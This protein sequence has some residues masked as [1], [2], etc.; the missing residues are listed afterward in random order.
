MSYKAKL[1]IADAE[2]I[3]QYEKKILSQIAPQYV[4][5]YREHKIEE[6]KKQELMAGYLLKT[7]LDIEREEQLVINENSL[8]VILSQH[9]DGISFRYVSIMFCFVCSDF[10]FLVIMSAISRLLYKLIFYRNK[11]VNII[12]QWHFF[13]KEWESTWK[14]T[15]LVLTFLKQ[16]FRIVEV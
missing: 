6:D 13:S 10:G 9:F 11:Y 3:L 15:F 16:T 5:K 1:I 12:S 2:H 8:T 7:Y 14:S 4:K